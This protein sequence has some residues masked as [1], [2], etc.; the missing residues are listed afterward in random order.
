MGCHNRNWFWYRGK[1][2]NVVPI[3][4]VSGISTEGKQLM[5]F[6]LEP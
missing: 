4:A 1:A 5:G 6:I 3:T 2:S